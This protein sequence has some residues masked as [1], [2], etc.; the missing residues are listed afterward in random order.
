VSI[1]KQRAAKDS[2]LREFVAYGVTA[3]GLIVILI[4][5]GWLTGPADDAQVMAYPDEVLE[6]TRK[7]RDV[8][9][10]PAAPLRFQVSV[11]YDEGAG[12]AWYPKGEPEI[13]KAMVE[14]GEL[15]PVA[16]RVGPEP[17]VLKGK[18]GIGKYGGSWLRLN[19]LG[20]GDR[21]TYTT[22]V[23]FSPQG[24]P[25]VPHVAK[26]WE[27]S[28]D[29]RE[30]TF[31]LRRGMKWSDGHPFTAEDI[32]YWFEEEMLNESVGGTVPEIMKVNGK[33]GKVVTYPDDPHRLTFSF[34][35][36]NGVFA[37]ILGT[38]AGTRVISSP[39]HYRRQFHP[40]HADAEALAALRRQSQM[41]SARAFYWHMAHRQNP[42]HPRLWQWII[43]AHKANPPETAVR[44]PYYFCVDERGNQLPY[45]DQIMADK[46]SQ[47]LVAIK[48]AGGGA[49][50]QSRY[51]SYDQYTYLMDQR[52]KG[53][54][55]LYHWYGGDRSWFVL[56]PNLNRR[57]SPNHPEWEKKRDLMREKTFR[58]ALSLAINRDSV[59]K[60]EY[61]YQAEP[62]QVAP[63]RESPFFHEKAFK[64]Y[65]DFDPKRANR[66]LNDLGLTRRDR[67]G[68]RT[69][70]DGSR[71][72]WYID[73]TKGLTS[74]RP[75]QFVVNDWQA[76]GIRTIPRQRDRTL[77]STEREGLLHDF[78]VWITNGEHYPLI[79]PRFFAPVQGSFFSIGYFQWL[80]TGGLDGDPKARGEALPRDHPLFEAL[81]HYRRA[82]STGNLNE[83]VRLFKPALDI[84][85]EQVWSINICTTPPVL[86]VVN[87]N[88]RNFPDTAVYSWDFL[89]PGNACPEVWY[90]EKDNNSPG[91]IAAIKEQ[92]TTPTLRPNDP[93]MDTAPATGQSQE[94]AASSESANGRFVGTVIRILIWGTILLVVLMVCL[95]HPFIS[96]RLAIMVPT[97]AIISV[98]VFTVI[99]LP[100]GDYLTSLIVRLE[101]TGD[102]AAQQEI[103][104]LTHMFHLDGSL[105]ERYARWLGLSWFFSF[106]K[107]DEGLLQGHL[108]LSME[109]RSP[110]NQLVGDRL[111]LTFLISLCTILFTWV[112]ALPTGIYSAVRQYSIG[113]Y[114]FTF[115]GFI[116]MCVPA[117]LLALLLMYAASELFGVSIG[118][119]LSAEFA[120]QPEWDWPKVKDLLKH[121]WLP[122]VVLGVGGTGGMIRVMRGNLLDELKKPYVVT[123]RAKGM[124]PMKL[125]VKYP[126]RI[127]LNPFI[128]GIGHIF[129]QL[130]SGG[131]IVAIVLSLPTVGPLMLEA[132]MTQDMYLAGS[133]LMVLSLLGVFGTLVSDLL[134]L[135][136]DPR[137]RYGGGGDE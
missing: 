98:I 34:P 12:A 17:C 63:G 20:A 135:C 38:Y 104:E 111:L 62:A 7:L 106:E 81:M 16:E 44:N 2:V 76:V 40:D 66:M 126:V 97:L 46:C 123:A 103:D 134:L 29:Y 102:T 122:V 78:N 109:T 90:L 73:Y 105:P 23:R 137:I 96:R 57:T 86:V 99:Q 92:I 8:S 65:T 59:I 56:Q 51:L 119:L 80:R 75:V 45:I 48:A 127:A 14:N 132:L 88:L 133:M 129:P 130:V 11:D 70:T 49:T 35:D 36:P 101:Q 58:Q 124:R 113:D 68:F 100:P 95:R 93:S 72:T 74:D 32:R 37:A 61:N 118:G 52:E 18:D 120:T 117:F 5:F 33:P 28:P 121:I 10:D 30:W 15:P 83:Q 82:C 3:A 84:A 71:M 4:F 125:L 64:A 115:A 131:A 77:W 6:A 107:E 108:G 54:Y 112:L 69:F 67:E 1:L 85:A 87:N 79:Q 25:I 19:H 136:L 21:T 114:I 31:H 42:R 60:A 26:A 43:R 39:A 116:G 50:F 53:N 9:F 27:H 22:L 89:S 13:L 55:Q 94:D 128:S 91:A 24:F 110:V 47:D 41:P